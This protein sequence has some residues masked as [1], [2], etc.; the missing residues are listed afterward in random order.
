MRAFGCPQP[1][2][3]RYS[4]HHFDLSFRIDAEGTLSD[5][6]TFLGHNPLIVPQASPP[7]NEHEDFMQW[8]NMA[9]VPQFPDAVNAVLE[10]ARVL[11][12]RGYVHLRDW[13][14]TPATGGLTLKGGR[15]IADAGALELASLDEATWEKLWALID[16]TIEFPRGAGP[17]P[18]KAQFRTNGRMVWTTA[19]HED[20]DDDD[21]DDELMTMHVPTKVE[22]L[23]HSRQFF[24]VRCET[25]ELLFF[26]MV[27][28]LFSLML[29]HEPSNHL[30][31]ILIPK[32]YLAATPL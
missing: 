23:T 16:Y 4:G 25:D 20:D 1:F 30:H 17:R 11:T 26:V 5:L 28:S 3:F 6:P 14:S 18:E 9:G 22:D 12:K 13:D 29:E 15:D 8:H 21:G 2:G 7:Q 24:Y 31:S 27:N 19:V 32:S 10:A